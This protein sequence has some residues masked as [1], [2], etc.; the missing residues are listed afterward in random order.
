MNSNAHTQV[1]LL[2]L[3][4]GALHVQPATNRGQDT[5]CRRGSRPTP[6]LITVLVGIGG[7]NRGP[8]NR[9]Q[10]VSA[11]L[12]NVTAVVGDDVDHGLEVVVE[13][14]GQLLGAFVAMFGK[15]F[16]ERREPRDVSEQQG[17]LGAFTNGRGGRTIP[18]PALHEG[19]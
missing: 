15:L 3:L 12:Q 17:T 16:R 19:S 18:Q 1:E 5:G 10:R 4:H 8:E 6:R 9:Q 2:E 11:E 14:K 13:K 7:R